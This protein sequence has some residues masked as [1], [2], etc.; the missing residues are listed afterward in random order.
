VFESTG[1]SE[2]TSRRSQTLHHRIAL[3]WL[4]LRRQRAGKRERGEEGPP[5]VLSPTIEH[6][7]TLFSPRSTYFVRHHRPLRPQ[8]LEQV[9][10]SAA[11]LREQLN[12]LLRAD[13]GGQGQELQDRV[14]MVAGRES[15]EELMWVR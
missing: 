9:A 6:G 3:L 4:R 1:R 12:A 2:T 14:A 5:V 11:T 10:M 7:P 13:L 15:K 8:L